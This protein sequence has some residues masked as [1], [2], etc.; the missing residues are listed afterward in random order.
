MRRA[1]GEGRR[2][3]WGQ[4]SYLFPV[5]TRVKRSFEEGHPVQSY[6]KG[7]RRGARETSFVPGEKKRGPH[8]DSK[9]SP[10]ASAR[11]KRREKAVSREPR[12]K[13][14][15]GRGGTHRDCIGKG[16][17]RRTYYTKYKIVVKEEGC[18]LRSRCNTEL[19]RRFHI[20]RGGKKKK[21]RKD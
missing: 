20:Q 18:G 21:K 5:G 15:K 2:K 10:R 6:K 19:A 13:K 1:G 3:R 16:D 8:H 11:K 7:E 4:R 17:L 14:E 9:K 12:L